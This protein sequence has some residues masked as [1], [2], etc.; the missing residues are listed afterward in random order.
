MIT[1]G[2]HQSCAALDDMICVLLEF[3]AAIVKLNLSEAD[4]LAVKVLFFNLVVKMT[5][6]MFILNRI[7]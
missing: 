1:A 7:Y 2:A 3:A 6:K 4:G 5:F